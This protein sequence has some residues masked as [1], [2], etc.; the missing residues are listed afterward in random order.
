[1]ASPTPPVIRDLYPYL[2]VRD[3][4]A[5]IE[6]YANAFGAVERFRL[7]EPNGRVGHAEVVIGPAIVMLSDEYPEHGILAP[8]PGDRTTV[9]IHLHVEDVDAVFER[10][11]T[12]GA[13]VVRPLADAFY[14]ER[15]G[16][17]RDPFGHEWLLG[18]QIEQVA[19]EEMQR[20]YTAL[21]AEE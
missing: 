20:R 8:Q 15:G 19:P 14:G 13:S 2:R 21:L 3:A 10:A 16:T 7:S 4:R 17:L 11:V 1:M 5:A 6:F 18:S 9:S 12:A